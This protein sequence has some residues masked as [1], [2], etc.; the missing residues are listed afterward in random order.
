MMDGIKENIEFR[1]EPAELK[2]DRSF[3][4]G[5]SERARVGIPVGT[6]ERVLIGLRT[7]VSSI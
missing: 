2:A 6:G 5:S 7:C 4:G 3:A 1:F